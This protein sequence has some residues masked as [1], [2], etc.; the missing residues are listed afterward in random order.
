MEIEMGRLRRELK[1][2]IIKIEYLQNQ[3]RIQDMIYFE[4]HIPVSEFIENMLQRYRNK[5][6]EQ[7]Y[8][9]EYQQMSDEWK[10]YLEVLPN[11]E[12]KN[13]IYYIQNTDTIPDKY[14]NSFY[15]IFKEYYEY[16]TRMKEENIYTNRKNKIQDMWREWSKYSK[17]FMNIMNIRVMTNSN[18][19]KEVEMVDNQTNNREIINNILNQ[20][21]E[22]NK[23]ST[24]GSKKGGKV[25]KKKKEMITLD[26]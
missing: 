3:I 10:Q 11:Y 24:K 16:L 9:E 14:K 26:I 5:E 25:E 17:I 22:F 21:I 12:I 20:R 1:K 4:K 8:E 2:K 6:N 13:I 15:C 19:H 7:S 23:P 18:N